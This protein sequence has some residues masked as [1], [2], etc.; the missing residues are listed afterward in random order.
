MTGITIMTEPLSVYYKCRTMARKYIRRIPNNYG[1]HYSVTRS[2]FDGFQAIGFYDYN[3]R[4]PKA[5]LYE[6]VHVLSGIP[7]LKYGID[8]KRKGVVKRLTAGPNFI[9]FSDWVGWEC[10]ID[11]NIDCLLFPSQ[12]TIDYFK[13][14]IPEL[15]AKAFASGVDEKEFMPRDVERKYV[16]LYLKAVDSY[17]GDYIS[18]ILK[19]SGFT[20]RII[21]Y[22]RYT[23]KEYK[24]LL[25]QSIFMISLSRHDTQG[26]YLAEA[27]AMDCPTLCWN[28]HFCPFPNT[29]THL[30]GN[31]LGSPYVCKENGMMFDSIGEL[32]DI[33]KK[34]EK[35]VTTIHP[36]TWLLEN[37]T[38]AVCSRRFLKLIR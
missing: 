21:K 10:L 37:M 9:N 38:D 13:R 14:Y 2:L 7:A 11:E 1:G 5:D 4:P 20:P 26:L 19:S 32:E 16:L 24:Q 3:Y 23:L 27:W 35:L 30:E 29:G 25:N 33:I 12:N 8:L 6:H 15:E 17:W 36:R 28:S 34:Y 22:G 31:Q 18:H